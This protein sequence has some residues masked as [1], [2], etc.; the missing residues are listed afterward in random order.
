MVVD[1]ILVDY[2]VDAAF[3][4]RVVDAL[5][6]WAEEHPAEWE[7]LLERCRQRQSVPV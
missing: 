5:I 1:C 3:R 6:E 2:R 4:D 7:G